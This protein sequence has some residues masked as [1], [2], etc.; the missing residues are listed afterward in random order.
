MANRPAHRIHRGDIL[1]Q[2]AIG[3]RYRV[4]STLVDQL[5][6]QPVG[7]ND[8]MDFITV[9]FDDLTNWTIIRPQRRKEVNSMPKNQTQR[10]GL[11]T[12]PK[13]TRAEWLKRTK[14]TV[15]LT[16]DELEQLA[17]L[18]AAGHVLL[19]DE[20]SVSPKLKGAM[21]RL[22]INTKGL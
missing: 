4:L 18:L 7:S 9:P 17:R 6:L 1:E 11:L 15:S 19:R 12:P 20:K 10:P 14:T 16:K 5:L 2:D 3:A 13:M 21:S 22:G 8:P